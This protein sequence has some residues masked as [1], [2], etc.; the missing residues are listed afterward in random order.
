MAKNDKNKQGVDR[1]V[2]TNRKARHQYHLTDRL[3]AGIV[4]HGSEVK[5][6]RGGQASIAEA[7][8]RIT[9]GGVWIIGLHIPEYADA[10][11][12][13]HEPARRRKLLLSRREIRKLERQ[14]KLK[15]TTL[16]PLDIHFNERGFAK[17]TI[18]MAT[19][20]KQHDK[21]A[22]LKKRDLEREARSY[23]R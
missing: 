6:V 22:D 15:G 14:I 12:N 10:T 4:L 21:R 17:I 9:D 1:V 18:A 11:Y 19:G 13:N 5:S 3:E 20:K 8:C 2:A 7:Y 16:V 23:K